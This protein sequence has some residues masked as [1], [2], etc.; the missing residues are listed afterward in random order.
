LHGD[1]LTVQFTEASFALAG[2]LSIEGKPLYLVNTHLHSAPQEDSGL[3]RRL[4]A[5]LLAG[6]ITSTGFA[7]TMEDWRESLDLQA[8]E[9]G[10]LQERLHELAPDVPMILGGDLNMPAERD[11]LSGFRRR[12]GFVDACGDCL[13]PTWDPAGNENVRFSMAPEDACGKP[14]DP[15]G[16]IDAYANGLPARIDHLL[17]S[18]HFRPEAVRTAAV[19]LD[20]AAEGLHA[21]D[22]YGVMA[23]IDL[24]NAMDGKR[25]NRSAGETTTEPLPILA[26]DTDTGFGY[27]LKLFALNHLRA[28]ESFDLVLFNSTKGERWY[29]FV[30]SLPDFELRQGTIYPL[31]ID[32][33]VDYDKWIRNSF[34][35]IGNRS[36]FSRRELYT[37]EPL[38]ITLT[39][40]RGVT[41]VFVVQAGLR[42]LMVRNSGYADTSALLALFPVA[43]VGRA[44]ATSV[45]ASMRFDSRDSY[46]NPTR[47]L[48]LQGDLEIAPRFGWTNVSYVRVGGLVQYYTELFYPT[49]VLAAR[50][51]FQ[52]HVGGDVPVQML[53]PIGGNRTLRGFVQDRYLDRL[54]GVANLE[55]RFPVFWRFGGVV[56]YDLGKVWH[57]PGDI[58]LDRWAVNPVAGLRF[59]F[60][61]YVVRLDLGFG[62]E[63]TGFYLNFGHLF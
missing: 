48:V 53:L 36:S 16:R 40:A 1:V 55:I 44:T 39:V 22:H 42:Y 8:A 3:V 57:T 6:V 21:S 13:R 26:Y 34:F 23:E 54:A 63:T 41:P 61:T 28:R 19:V 11:T 5:D 10:V 33:T 35:G 29:R 24:R 43:G 14:L 15:Y 32:L 47:G 27:G 4:E 60:D 25:S 45:M 30:F 38:D 12:N 56:G 7:G 49:T 52:S 58:D 46:I 9:L 62:P 18:R 20:A 17:L 59:V 50:L 31:A 51:W 37:R 2:S